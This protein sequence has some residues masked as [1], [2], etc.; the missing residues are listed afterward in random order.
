MRRSPFACLLLAGVSVPA[1]ADDLTISS[2]VKS[3]VF[4]ATAAN[5]SPGDISIE[6][7]ASVN[8]AVQ[9]AAVTLNSNNTIDNIG[10]IQNTFSGNGAI[11]VHIIGG[12][13]GTFTSEAGSTTEISAGGG[14]G[15]KNFGLVLDGASAFNGNI[16][17]GAGSNL[18]AIGD[19]SI[20]IAI[21]APLNGSLSNGAISSLVGQNITGMLITAPISGS[22]TTSGAITVVGVAAPSNQVLNPLSGSAVAI[23]SSISGGI[24]NAGPTGTGDSTPISALTATSTVAVY[25]IQPSIAGTNAANII[26]GG[27]SDTVNPNFSF[28]NRGSI[29][30][31][32]DQ[33]GVSTIGVQIGET[34]TAANTVTLTGGIYNNGTISAAAESDNIIASKVSPANTNATALI[35][36]NGAAINSSGTTAQA[37]LNNGSIS[38]SVIGNLQIVSQNNSIQ[39]VSTALLIQ[40][41]GSLPSLATAGTISATAGTSNVYLNNLTAYAIR[42]LS[43]TLTTITNTGAISAIATPLNNNAQQTTAIEISHTSANE[44]ITTSGPITGDILFGSAGMNGSVAGNQLVIEGTTTTGSIASV[45]GSIVPAAGGTIDVQV[46]RGGTGGVLNTANARLTTLGVGEAGTVELALNQSS[47]STPVISATGPVKFGFGSAVTLVPTSFLPNSGTYTLIHSNTSL[48]FSDFSAATAQPIPFLFN[49]SIAQNGNDLVITLQRKT[50]AELGLTGN[51]V[52]L[53]EPLAQSALTDNPFGA[54]LLSLTNAEDVQAA[55]NANVPDVGGGVRA[56]A[57]A[58][59]DSVT[60]VVGA[61]ERNLVLAA[62]NQQDEFRFWAQ[63]VYDGVS[64]GTTATTSGFSGQGQGV[65]LGIEFGALPDIRYGLAF[66]F[67]ASSESEAHP[68]DDKTDG[69]WHLLSF[70]AGWRPGN[71]FITPELNIGQADYTSRRSIPIGGVLTRTANANWI[72]YLGSAAVTAGYVLPMGVFQLIPELS[73]DGLYLHQNIINEKNAGAADL[74]IDAQNQQSLRGFAGFLTQGAFAWAGGTVQPQLLLGWSYDFLNKPQVVNAFFR[75][76][77]TATFQL[78]GPDFGANR[79][80]GGVGLNYAVGAWSAGINYDVSLSTGAIAQSATFSLSS[81]F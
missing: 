57:V 3:P 32:A 29:T 45:A 22:L 11:G 78:T 77:P 28:L 53:Y 75:Q 19:N 23:G 59:T 61:R 63:E 60:G 48:T 31:T 71:F 81:R 6:T 73:V 20:G 70:Y 40:P 4:T 44:T 14:S 80:I 25:A 10:V 76:A 21:Q 67:F 56:L 37:L 2:E 7:G 33:P 64:A 52:A 55:I 62:A 47:A 35:I 68:A 24:L 13:T 74:N 5:N 15:T 79:F 46:S 58:M 49:G 30:N 16:S 42:D 12:T 18:V 69:D 36:G 72:G 54:A 39:M 50:A 41:G 17:L 51:S 65:A 34:G 38:S 43:G 26:I 8:V 66:T 1:L 9:G 27:S